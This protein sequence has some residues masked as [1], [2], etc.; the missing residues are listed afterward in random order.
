MISIFSR[1]STSKRRQR[2]FVLIG[3]LVLSVLY[4]ALMELLLID[5]SRALNEAQ[6]FRARIVAVTLA[7]SGAELAALQMV[8][9]AGIPPLPFSDFQGTMNGQF[10]RSGPDFKIDGEGTTIGVITQTSTVQLQ[11]RIDSSGAV[12]KIMID[13]TAHAQ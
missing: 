1:A 12:A 4:F 7:E 9:G 10:R 13:Y 5:S 6:R 11:G 2:G 8:T 3:A